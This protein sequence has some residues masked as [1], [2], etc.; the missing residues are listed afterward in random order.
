MTDK[1]DLWIV[2]DDQ[3]VTQSL[4]ALLN[5]HGYR[6]QGFASARAF[7]DFI[8][9]DRPGILVSDITMPGMSG[10]E[11]RHALLEMGVDVPVVFITGY[12]DLGL[13]IQALRAGA[14]DFIEK[15]FTDAVLLASLERVAGQAAPAA[16]RSRLAGIR[17]RFETLTEREREVMSLVAAGLSTKDVAQRLGISP[18]T[19]DIHRAHLA[20]KMRAA[21]LAE[22][23]RQAVLLGL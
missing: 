12:A 9:P 7:L 22:L 21:S 6:T 16:D 4:C 13:A 14:A 1:P 17:A 19:V 18:R 20:E 11:L 23:V 8:A 15:P 5:S 2:D 10:I 3:A